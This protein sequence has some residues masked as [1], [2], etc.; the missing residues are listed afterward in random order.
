MSRLRLVRGQSDGK[1][2]VGD[3]YNLRD[4]VVAFEKGVRPSFHGKEGVDGGVVVVSAVVVTETRTRVTVLWQ[5]GAREEY[6]SNDL[7]PYLNVDEYD[8]WYVICG[9]LDLILTG[10]TLF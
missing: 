3:K 7:I 6:D 9:P 8:C 2:R 4:P 10:C 1:P 5:S